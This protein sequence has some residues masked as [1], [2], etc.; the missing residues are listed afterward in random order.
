MA[1]PKKPLLSRQLIAEAALATVDATGDLTIEQVSRRL[2]VAAS[3]LY[4]HVSGRNEIIELMRDRLVPSDVAELANNSWEM[5]LT[6]FITTYRNS[7][8]QHPRLIPLLTL[9]TVSGT[10][11]AQFYQALATILRN[12]GFA[13]TAL[14]DAVTTVDG[15]ALGAAL[16]LAAPDVVWSVER[17]PSGPMRDALD[18]APEG[19][20]RSDQSFAFGLEVLVAGLRQ[21]V[22]RSN[23]PI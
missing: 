11:T 3:S 8:G 5:A 17:F 20:T 7:V 9:N 12:A 10:S 6:A 15:F 16:D 22:V 21:A 19:R 18:A 4:N 1:R 14:L 23:S 2:G 13:D